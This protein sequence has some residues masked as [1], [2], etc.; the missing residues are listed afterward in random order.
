MIAPYDRERNPRLSKL[1]SLRPEH[2]RSD[3]LTGV[4]RVVF[5]LGAVVCIPSVYMALREGLYV[6]AIGDTLALIAVAAL[7]L[8]KRLAH[9]PRAFSFCA[10]LYLVGVML[11]ALVGP[12]SQI[13]LLGFSVMTT[14]LLGLRAGVVTLVVNALTLLA[15]G[16]LG[17]H[18]AGFVPPG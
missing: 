15:F 5:A 18:A 14:T 6:V 12:V 10:I 16:Y 9:R 11:L 3:L 2:W 7:L 17:L 4:L 8:A 13:Y 1:V